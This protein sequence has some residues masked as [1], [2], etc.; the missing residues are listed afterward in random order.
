MPAIRVKAPDGSFVTFPEGTATSVMESAMRQHFAPPPSRS[1]AFMQEVNRSDD[2]LVGDIKTALAPT[3]PQPRRPNGPLP[4]NANMIDKTLHFLAGG[5]TG[6]GEVQ[7]N[8]PGGQAALAADRVIGDVIDLPVSLGRGVARFINP[9][10]TSEQANAYTAAAL[11]ALPF[12]GPA[13]KGLVKVPSAIAKGG[14]VLKNS[15][16]AIANILKAGPNATAATSDVRNQ[17]LAEAV[18]QSKLAEATHAAAI[19]AK[20]AADAAHATATSNVVANQTAMEAAQNAARNV[21]PIGIGQAQH[22]SE[23][24]R[25]VQAEVMANANAAQKAKAAAFKNHQTA[26]DDLVKAQEDKGVYVNDLAETKALNKKHQDTLNP[27]PA[28]APT[29]T[30]APSA[31][32]ARAS[33][34]VLDALKEN[35]VE[36]SAAKAAEAEALGY[37][38]DIV[39]GGGTAANP[40]PDRYFRTFKTKLGAVDELN[41]FANEA[42]HAKDPVSGFEGISSNI[43]KDIS[44]DLKGIQNAYTDGAS[45]VQKDAYKA[46]LA[47]ADRFLNG[48]G[49]DIAATTGSTTIQTPTL[50]ASQI[51]GKI[52][53]GGA[54][55]YNQFKAIT[56]PVLARNFANNAVETAFLDP[57]T[58]MSIDYSTAAKMIKPG[59]QLGDI[60]NEIPEIKTQVAQ[61]MNTLSDARVNGVLADELKLKGMALGKAQSKAEKTQTA[62]AKVQAAAEESMVKFVNK[63]NDFKSPEAIKD[64]DVMPKAR[65]FVQDLRDNGHI[66][67]DQLNKFNADISNA[68][69]IVDFKTRRD[70]IVKKIPG[71]LAVT[72]VLGAGAGAALHKLGQ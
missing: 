23:Q 24:G 35:K 11:G 4:A 65:K 59:T 48:I 70:A 67:N 45:Q 34:M 12:V 43:W 5:D 9:K 19:E 51:P 1:Q 25:P 58:G 40:V 64:K 15:G 44:T 8:T 46:A 69:K 13:A 32:Q 68:E 37:K 30:S 22:L 31:G 26:I 49:G 72:G 3:P 17:A 60:I 47:N 27:N 10:L 29:A 56:N 62:S 71:W 38:V 33:K 42:S 66:T 7:T 36:L 6:T 54:D 39:P 63:A 28:T 21:K 52:I 14:P 61:H 55:V 16:Q 20:A 18:R 53:A 2:N 50:P 41:R 57:V